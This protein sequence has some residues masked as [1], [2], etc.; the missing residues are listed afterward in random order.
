MQYF[1][2]F[3]MTIIS[4]KYFSVCTMHLIVFPWKLNTTVKYL[5]IISHEIESIW[6]RRLQDFSV[7]HPPI[8]KRWTWQNYWAVVEESP[9]WNNPE[10]L[11]EN[12]A[13]WKAAERRT[14]KRKVS[15]SGQDPLWQRYTAF[16]SA[17]SLSVEKNTS[18]LATL[19][20]SH[21]FTSTLF[22]YPFFLCH[23]G[24]GGA[25]GRK[26]WPSFLFSKEKRCSN[27]ERKMNWEKKMKRM[28]GE[29]WPEWEQKERRTHFHTSFN[30]FQR[31]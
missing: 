4:Q 1:F 24:G 31:S 29:H 16:W 23:W 20:A 15:N 7:W 28:S 2:L 30:I 12:V 27:R 11:D 9:L 26:I 8:L 10:M 14:L 5:V 18:S 6:Q 17:F 3:C 21:S 25:G 13:R 22:Y 19:P